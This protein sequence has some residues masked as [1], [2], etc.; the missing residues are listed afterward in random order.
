LCLWHKSRPDP[1]ACAP[2]HL[3]FR[4]G[5]DHA[6]ALG[7]TV[8]DPAETMAGQTAELVAHRHESA[9]GAGRL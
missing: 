9:L 4:I 5:P 8:M 6:M 1:A 7:V 3:R 2:N